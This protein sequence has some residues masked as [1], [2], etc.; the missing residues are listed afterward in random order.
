M[1]KYTPINVLQLFSWPVMFLRQPL[2]LGYDRSQQQLMYEV[3]V[4]TCLGN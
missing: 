4:Y 3:G 2:P 1:V